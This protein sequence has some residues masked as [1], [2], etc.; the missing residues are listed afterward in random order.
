VTPTV[1]A[2]RRRIFLIGL[3]MAGGAGLVVHILTDVSLPLAIGV[4]ALLG[5]GVFGF[6][7]SRMDPA[8][9]RALRRRAGVGLIAGVIGTLAYDAAR[10]G[11]VALFEM[12][13]K[14]FHVFHVFGELFIG[15]NHPEALIF[16]VGTLYHVS[17]GT[18]F[19]LAYTLV[20]RRPSWWTGALWGVGLELCMAFLY[21]SWLR[22]QMLR[23]FLEI[24]A[25]GHVVYGS[26]LGVVAAIGIRRLAARA[27]EPAAPPAVSDAPQP[28]EVP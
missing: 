11:V 9:R 16:A 27:A 1:P 3:P 8:G 13:F 19:G 21:P 22:I 10:Y 4:V 12:S 23:E 14:P 26:T 2:L 17:N 15:T 25:I 28:T 6:V 18:F 7:L 24:S 20:L 5:A